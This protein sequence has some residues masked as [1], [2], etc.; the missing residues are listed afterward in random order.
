MPKAAMNKD[1]CTVAW[2]DYIRLSWEIAGVQPISKAL[3]M[4][5]AP[6]HELGFRILTP[7]ATHHPTT[8]FRAHNVRHDS[9]W[10]GHSRHLR[11]ESRDLPGGDTKLTSTMFSRLRC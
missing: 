7:D 6:D 8:C 9:R 3:A 11:V 2:E 10:D 4:K 5:E 1:E